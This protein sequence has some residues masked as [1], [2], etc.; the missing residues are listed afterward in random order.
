MLLLVKLSMGRNVLLYRSMIIILWI[1]LILFVIYNTAEAENAFSNMNLYFKEKY[2]QMII[3]VTAFGDKKL[4]PSWQ[5]TCKKGWE[6]IPDCEATPVSGVEGLEPY[7]IKIN[8]DGFRD[9]EYPL[10][11]PDDS[12]RIVVLGDSFTFGWGVNIEETFT[13][14]LEKI[15]NEKRLE[16]NFEVLNFGVPG[17]NTE[18]EIEHFTKKALKYSPDLVILGFTNN[19][20]ESLK[21]YTLIEDYDYTTEKERLIRYNQLKD[22]K[23]LKN[24]G[25]VKQPLEE[26][27]SLSKKYGFNILL[28]AFSLTGYQQD[29]FE[30]LEKSSD[31]V[32]FQRASFNFEARNLFLHPLDKHPSPVANRLYAE[33]IYNIL[34][35]YDLLED[36]SFFGK[37]I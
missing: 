1:S 37:H 11:K 28:Y 21:F 35:E 36:Y 26:L 22:D 20:D 3:G 8:S 27:D 34:E 6:L 10:K 2:R 30:E 18:Q 25:F 16:K 5:D 24:I 31:N 12:F 7:Y 17:V 14:Q 29:F 15:L 4:M 32:Y 9:R 33:E 13:F 19:D 23:T